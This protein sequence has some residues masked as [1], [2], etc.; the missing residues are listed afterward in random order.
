MEIVENEH[1]LCTSK[2]T[3]RTCICCYEK[4]KTS[5]S[6][7]NANLVLGYD[8]LIRQIADVFAL[9]RRCKNHMYGCDAMMLQADYD[10][11]L[12]TCKYIMIPCHNKTCDHKF[13]ILTDDIETHLTHMIETHNAIKIGYKNTF[14]LINRRNY[15]MPINNNM[16]AFIRIHRDKE[17]DDYFNN[18]NSLIYVKLFWI[19]TKPK[20]KS[21]DI[22]FGLQK[23]KAVVTEKCSYTASCSINCENAFIEVI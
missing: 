10:K 1:M 4:M 3:H 19:N 16:F 12:A 21:Y 15:V 13:N 11:H 20:K 17:L 14:E 22:L 2:G 6:V 23:C 8:D 9:E 18:V 5:C 7:C